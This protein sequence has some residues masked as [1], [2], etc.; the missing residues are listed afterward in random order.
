MMRENVHYF[1]CSLSVYQSDWIS[2]HF[3][4]AKIIHQI[5]RGAPA[6]IYS[7]Q[8]LYRMIQEHH[9]IGKECSY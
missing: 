9:M 8:C 4:F 5:I 6:N 1:R 7:G 2:F 3:F